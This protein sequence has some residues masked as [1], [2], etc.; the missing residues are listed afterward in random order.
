MSQPATHA[1]CLIVG[2]AGLLLRGESGSGKTVL[3]DFLVEAARARGNLGLLVSDD[4]VH[5]TRRD[6]SLIACAPETISGKMEVRG[7]G[8][9]EAA[10]APEAHIDLVVDLVPVEDMER[11]PEV[12]LGTVRL[13]T[14]QLP[15]L[16][17][18]ENDP[19]LAVRLIRWAL[20]RLTPHSTDYI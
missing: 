14:V 19:V 10:F 18:P 20:R 13:E 12:P 3:T 15:Q 6:G 4:Y 16:D 17:C 8:L 7:F 11:L 9:A 1:N 5:L 2:T